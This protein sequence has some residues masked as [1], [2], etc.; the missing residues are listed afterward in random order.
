MI[1]VVG[2]R[3]FEDGRELDRPPRERAQSSGRPAS[4][5]G[6]AQWRKGNQTIDP[7][8]VALLVKIEVIRPCL[9]TLRQASRAAGSGR[10]N[11]RRG[12]AERIVQLRGTFGGSTATATIGAEA[13]CAAIAGKAIDRVRS[14]LKR[15]RSTVVSGSRFNRSDRLVSLT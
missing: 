6:S 12:S 4:F 7:L 5:R 2:L 15:R 14:L 10:Q 9:S 13:I 1:D 3:E 8:V 11:A